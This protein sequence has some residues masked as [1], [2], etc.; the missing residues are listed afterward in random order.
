MDNVYKR[1]ECFLPWN[2]QNGVFNSTIFPYWSAE[3]FYYFQQTAAGKFLLRIDISTG[4]KEKIFDFQ[5]L[6]NALSHQLKQ[7]INPAR[8]PLD[9]FSIHENPLQLRFTY[10]NNDWCYDLKKHTCTQGLDVTPANLK[11][12]DENWVLRTK[13]YN[14]V[15]TD[16]IH[17]QDFHLTMDGE[18]YY[19]YAS[20]PET[21]TRAVTQCIEGALPPPIALWSPDS[22]KVITHKLDQRKVNSLFL[23]QNAPEENQRPKLHNYRMSFSGDADLPLAKL[24]VVDVESRTVT[25]LKT[26]PLLSPYLTP[27]EFKWVWWSQDSQKIYFLRETRAAKELMLC[28]ADVNTGVTETLIIET[29]ET[30]IEPSQLFLWPHQVII[31]EDSQEIIWLSERSGYSHLYLYDM[32]SNI[33]KNPI[34]QG[35]WCVREVHFYD[36]EANWESV[37]FPV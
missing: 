18:C 25:P 5:Q 9:K 35:E 8:L 16:L 33:P 34:T 14:L 27:L 13:D 10:Q 20:S 24:M 11:S 12:P 22:H 17:H 36:E 26:E 21:N 29:A 30:Y 15:L 19:D 23:L 28:V 7:N 3:A 1:A 37:N 31:L 4:E 2:L 6:L 32:G